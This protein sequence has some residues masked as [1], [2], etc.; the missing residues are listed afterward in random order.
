MRLAREGSEIDYGFPM[1][2]HTPCFSASYS[3]KPLDKVWS[4]NTDS[5]FFSLTKKKIILEREECGGDHNFLFQLIPE[6]Q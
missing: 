4:A 5:E 3:L 2:S 6:G 1:A